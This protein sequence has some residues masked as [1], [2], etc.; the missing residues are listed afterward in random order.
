MRFWGCTGNLR[1]DQHLTPKRFFG[2]IICLVHNRETPI[3]EGK[4]GK[5]AVA[6]PQ[7]VHPAALMARAPVFHSM[8]LP[9]EIY[10]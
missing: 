5:V 9:G 2:P 1:A 6:G 3:A 8:L 10:A 7:A 4:L